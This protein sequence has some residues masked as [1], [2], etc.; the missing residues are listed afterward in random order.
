MHKGQRFASSSV[1]SAVL[2]TVTSVAWAQNAPSA[3]PPPAAQ[4]PGTQAPGAPPPT[5]PAPAL[6][7]QSDVAPTEAPAQPA[8]PDGSLSAAEADAAM[9]AAAGPATEVVP[10]ATPSAPETI[11]PPAA[12]PAPAPKLELSEARYKPGKG[13][14]L[15]S[16]DDQFSLALRLRAQFLYTL[17]DAPDADQVMH[18]FQIRRARVLASGHVF[19]KHNKYKVEL[20]MSPRDENVNSGGPTLTPLLDWHAEFDYIK[21]A[22]LRVGQYKVPFNRQRVI[23]S[24]DLQMVDRSLAQAEFNLDRD[25]GMHLHAQDLAGLDLFRYYAGVWINEGRDASE[26]HPLD[27]MY[28]ARVEV[29]PFGMF[30]DYREGDLERMDKPGLSLGAAYAYLEN[31]ANERGILGS[32]PEDGGTTDIHVMTAD[33]LFKAHGF[34]LQSEFYYRTGDRTAGDAVDDAGEP[35]PTVAPRDGLGWFVQSG[36]LLGAVPVEFSG[37]YSEVRPV[38]S[39][40]SLSEERELGAAVSWYPGAHSLK[41]QGDYFRLWE[42]EIADGTNQFRVQLQVSH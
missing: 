17:V 14:I 27:M 38:G 2:A 42:D 29:L 6:P 35:I 36:Y 5:T 1:L 7:T 41:L 12:E 19:G 13:L 11:E 33:L 24:G 16:E 31:A 28:I 39:D 37:R 21:D 32:P 30:D 10:P 20:A 4:A 18:G 23:S 9:P 34:S 22:T 3:A 26:M 8:Q 15:T 40:S 25:V